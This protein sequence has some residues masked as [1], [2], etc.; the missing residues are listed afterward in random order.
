MTTGADQRNPLSEAVA[1]HQAGQLEAAARG[2]LGILQHRPRDFNALHLLGVLRLSQGQA[3]E[4]VRLTGQALAGL[5]GRG[6]DRYDGPGTPASSREIRMKGRDGIARAV[7]L[8]ASG[9]RLVVLPSLRQ[10]NAEDA[11]GRP[12]HRDPP[13]QGGRIDMTKI[14]DLHERWLDEPA[15]QQAHA[16]SDAEFTLARELIAARVCAGLT[17]E[18]LASAWARPSR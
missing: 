16:A 5:S 3:G 10:E 8:A 9:R 13:G 4:A 1:L 14:A 18:Q 2:Y 15:Y 17:Q 12:R 6:E 11:A 7:S